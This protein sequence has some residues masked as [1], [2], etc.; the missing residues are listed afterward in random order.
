MDFL[1]NLLDNSNIPVITAFLLGL[2]TAISPCPLATNI[3]AI[4]F[5]SKDIGNRN[6][7]FL[8]GLLYTLGRVVAYTVLGIILISILKEGSSMFSLQ[9]GISKYGE[10]LIAPVLIF[11][12]V[13]ML[14]GDRLNLPKFGFSGT[15]KAEKLKGNL[16]S[17]L[18]GVLFALA[19][20]PTSGLFYF[21]MLIPMSAAEPGG[22][23]LPIVYAVATGLPVILVAWI[24]AYSVA[25]IGKFYNRI[26]VFQKWF[27]RV[28]AVLFI[29]VGIYYAYINYL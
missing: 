29:A 23:L 28:V 12:G 10:I 15:G 4:G 19:F 3:T 11:V 22:Y 9:K 26:Q 20:C 8:G 13:F 24:L 2:L 27:N 25:G 5:I 16:G 21:G 1:Q 7:I 17:L 6:K 14:F 18:L